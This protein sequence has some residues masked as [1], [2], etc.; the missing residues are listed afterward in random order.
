MAEEEQDL[1][2]I[3]GLIVNGG[4]AKSSAFEAIYAAKK[5]DFDTADA[6]LKEADNFLVEAHNSQTGMLTQEAQGNHVKVTLLTVHSQDHLM[7][8]ITFRDLAGEI[9]DLYKRLDQQQAK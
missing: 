4:N 9:V 5:G 1:Q 7:N 3:M 6:K 2:T 8:A